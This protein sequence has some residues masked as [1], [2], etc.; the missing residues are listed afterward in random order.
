MGTE[1]STQVESAAQ[2][3]GG[4]ALRQGGTRARKHSE[5]RVNC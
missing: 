5:A 2:L 3:E 1:S 4:K